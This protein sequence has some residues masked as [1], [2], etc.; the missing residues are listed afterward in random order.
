ML[1]H[2]N[3]AVWQEVND[4]CIRARGQA[5]I[6]LNQSGESLSAR[7]HGIFQGLAALKVRPEPRKETDFFT[8]HGA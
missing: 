5:Q 7:L 8:F 4:G 3:N 6:H 1:C 2:S